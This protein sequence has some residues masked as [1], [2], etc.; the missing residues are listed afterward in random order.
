[1]DFEA[2]AAAR[3]DYV[4]PDLARRTPLR[5]V[6]IDEGA[7]FAVSVRDAA[8]HTTKVARSFGS[9]RGS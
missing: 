9:R 1:M 6:R 4:I 2:T 3:P 7:V 5:R 8:G